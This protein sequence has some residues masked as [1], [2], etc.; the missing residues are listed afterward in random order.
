MWQTVRHL[1][2]L[3]FYFEETNQ[4]RSSNMDGCSPIHTHTRWWFQIFFLFTAILRGNGI[5]FDLH[6]FR[7]WVGLNHQLDDIFTY[8]NGGFLW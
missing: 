1:L 7:K 2:S 3:F 6:I 5:Q 8:M 4:M